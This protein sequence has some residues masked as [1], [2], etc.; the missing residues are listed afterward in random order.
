MQLP[1]MRNLPAVVHQESTVEM[2][3]PYP[4][5][6][7]PISTV[8][9][10]SSALWTA[11]TMRSPTNCVYFS[12]ALPLKIDSIGP[13]VC[14]WLAPMS[15][16]SAGIVVCDA[17]DC[18]GRVAQASLRHTTVDADDRNGGIIA[19]DD[20]RHASSG[21]CTVFATLPSQLPIGV[22]AAGVISALPNPIFVMR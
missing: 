20:A 2:N 11:S 13:P 18:A 15:T 1:R 6:R 21:S 10:S 17:I 19:L 9:D 16:C 4:P 12:F 5:V 14:V 7:T 3:P 22:P 8:R